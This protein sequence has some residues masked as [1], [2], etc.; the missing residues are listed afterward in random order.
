MSESARKKDRKIMG[1]WI[2]FGAAVGCAIGLAMGNLT[3]G[4]GPGVAI[5]VL[6]GNK[7][8]KSPR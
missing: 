2:C 6:I 3:L 7:K 8:S 4:I 5:G 1:R